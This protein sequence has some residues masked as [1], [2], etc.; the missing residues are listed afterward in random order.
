M[1][2]LAALLPA[3]IWADH[4]PP[5]E[6]NVRYRWITE[7]LAPEV[8][9]RTSLENM[10]GESP[11]IVAVRWGGLPKPLQSEAW[12][13][14]YLLHERLTDVVP[15]KYQFCN[16]SKSGAADLSEGELDFRVLNYREDTIFRLFAGWEQ[17]VLL[18]SSQPL[19]LLKPAQPSG[20]HTAL[21]GVQGEVAITWTSVAAEKQSLEP[22]AEFRVLSGSGEVLRQGFAKAEL[23]TS[24]ERQELCAAPANAEGWRDPGTFYTVVIRQLEP[25]CS[26]RYRVGRPGAWSQSASFRTPPAEGS[27]VRILAFGDMGQKPLDG[28]RQAAGEDWKVQDYSQ[29]DPGARDTLDMLMKDHEAHPADM[30]L[31]NGD[32]SYAMGFSAVWESFQQAIE[33]LASA[34]PWM[35][36]IGNHERDWPASGSSEGD[37]DSLGEC[38]VPAMRR[39]PAVPYA[40]SQLPPHDQPWWAMRFGAVQLIAL[41]TEHAFTRGSPQYFFLLESLGAVNRSRTPWVVLVGHRPYH[42]SSDW[43]GDADFGERLRASVGEV[44]EQ[45]VDLILGAHHHSYQRTCTFRGSACAEQGLNVVNKTMP[46]LFRYQDD[47][48]FGYCRISADRK[49]LAVEYVHSNDGKVYDE[50]RLAKDASSEISV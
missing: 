43:S 6:S 20:I 14:L 49:E 29:G 26:V 23:R 10:S 7:A 44:V 11:E 32:L 35:V 9:M 48:H 28:S 47:Q 1:L 17:P 33:P 30:V 38:G 22:G 8:S 3:L 12:I 34:V 31:H 41:S 45:H 5:A 50:I 46:P 2:A 40:S 37:L 39:F 15:M 4:S 25:G 13:G 36:T 21:T 19:R 24:Y 42:V 16:H 18:A 27:A